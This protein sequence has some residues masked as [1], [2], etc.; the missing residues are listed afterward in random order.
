MSQVE[1]A[2]GDHRRG[3]LD[4]ARNPPVAFFFSFKL[5]LKFWLLTSIYLYLLTNADSLLELF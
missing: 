1:A 3:D 4:A 2:H 5:S